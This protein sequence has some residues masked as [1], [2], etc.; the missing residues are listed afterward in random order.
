MDLLELNKNVGRQNIFDIKLKI[1][2]Q[3]TKKVQ[4]SLKNTIDQ[5]FLNTD[6]LFTQKTHLSGKRVYQE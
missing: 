5:E 6:Q 1:Y 4:A 2:A 3:L